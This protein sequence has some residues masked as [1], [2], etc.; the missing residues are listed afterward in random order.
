VP[1]QN[2]RHK[3]HDTELQSALAGAALFHEFV[4]ED[5]ELALR[6]YHESPT[7]LEQNIGAAV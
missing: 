5:F 6:F 4:T 1:V 7:L 3:W 2:E